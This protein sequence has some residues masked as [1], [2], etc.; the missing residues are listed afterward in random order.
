MEE[1]ESSMYKPV[2]NFPHAPAYGIPHSMNPA[3]MPNPHFLTPNQ[4]HELG[5]RRKS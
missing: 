5:I 1:Y 2:E 4:M 3:D